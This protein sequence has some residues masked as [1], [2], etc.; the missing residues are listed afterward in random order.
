MNQQLLWNRQRG[1]QRPR[2]NS[3]STSLV[4]NPGHPRQNPQAPG[5]LDVFFRVSATLDNLETDLVLG[6][7][8]PHFINYIHQGKAEHRG[9][10]SNYAQRQRWQAR[11]HRRW[12]DLPPQ[13]VS[14]SFC[15]HHSS[16]P[17]AWRLA[18]RKRLWALHLPCPPP[19]L[20]SRADG[21]FWSFSV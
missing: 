13:N 17:W 7:L 8:G 5:L 18:R 9:P 14:R 4:I 11:S 19:L 16:S 15:Q 2:R 3:C 12:P 21:D 1:T 6:I 20:V 10:A